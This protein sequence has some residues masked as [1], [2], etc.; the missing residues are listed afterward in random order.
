MRAIIALCVRR[1]GAVTALTLLALVLG[2]WGARDAPLDVFPEFVPSQVD[3]QTEA[4]GFSPQQVE[5]LVTKPVENAV[6]GASGLA[7]LRSE[8]IP[9]LSVVTI[10]FADN[11]DLHIA[12]QGIAER[13]S[14]IGSS[15]P[16][17][18]GVPKLSPMV[19][20]TMDLLKIGLVSD[21]VD[22]YTLR[23]T[24][25]WVIKPRL[26]AVPGV[27]H[28]IVFGG[29]V[30]QIQIQPDMQR[31]TS[32]GITLAEVADAARAAL[33]LR[34]AGFIDTTNQRVLMQSPIPAP[35]PAALANAVVTMRN[36]VPVRL[37]DIA[38]VKVA[39]AL[40]S[41]DT[42]IMG[43]PGILLSLASQYGANTLSTTLAVEQALSALRPAL[44]AQGITVYPGLQRPANFVER[45]LGNLRQ[46]LLIAGVLIF[47][48]LYLF[49]RDIRAA[50]IA[51]T[52]IPLSLLAAI[53]VLDRMG[54]TLNTM[55][56][57]GFAV[58]LGVLVDDAIIG[59]ENILRRLRENR[60]VPQPVDRLGVIREA[61]LEVRGPV[62]YAT[63]V[64]I[65]VFLPEIFTSS[66]Q[67]HFVG[68]LALAFIF[69]VVASL[70]VAMTATPAL[71]ALLLRDRDARAEARWL[72][73]LKSWQSRAVDGVA[74][75][76][77]VVAAVLVLC[78]VAAA[79]ALPFLGGTFMPDFREGHF[80]I[81]VS[82]SIPGTSLAAMLDVGKRI[83]AEVLA[84]PYVA[85]VE[86]Q[87]GRAELGED[88]WGPHRSEFHVELKPDADIDQGAAQDALRAI[89][90]HYP[91]LQSEVVTFLGDRIS[92]SLS[93]ET[94]QVAIK[95]FGDNLDDLD[96][97]G[98]R[99]VEALRKIPGVVDLEFKRQSGTP[100]IAIQLRPEALLASGLKAQ[101][102]LDTIE[103]AYS[104]T[105]VGQTFSGTRTVDAVVLLPDALRQQPAQLAQLMISGPTGPVPLSQIAS[106]G[107]TQDRY[108]IEHDGGQRR[109]SVNFN[110]KGASLQDVVQRAAQTIAAKVV[111]PTGVHTEFTGAAEEE[112]QT[113]NEL[114]LYSALALALIGMILFVSF[115]W[116]AN[117]YLVL[118]NL[119]FALVGSVAVIAATG[120]GLSLGTV[121]GLVTVF[122]VSAR[123]AILQL[124]HYEHLVEVEG[125]TWDIETVIRGAN[126]RLVPILMTA[127][128]TALGLAPLAFGMNLPGQEIEGPMAVTVLGGL[129]SST[130]LNLFVLPALARHYIKVPPR[131]LLT[132]NTNYA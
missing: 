81:Q 15:L 89:L 47:V 30:R 93:G 11:I 79:A 66:V 55:T 76:F 94:A 53:A 105:V 87:V 43:K 37:G 29:N 124:A 48:V 122:G 36:G 28:V 125:A 5:E 112:T 106:I 67:G 18:V 58:A 82:S 84:L 77:K 31:L 126:E 92:E 100:A 71:C 98:D 27:A 57:G 117:S 3:I 88:T 113:R 99:M 73:R 104:G 91:G 69:A 120:I 111:L 90:T 64:V 42:L 107:V 45:A 75:H 46:S 34:G 50:L 26:L 20:S 108:S 95:V 49:L 72:V 101:D 132:P 121:V 10:T 16:A 74:N 38:S 1:Y 85:S 7:T 114:L 123:N 129:V 65:A 35:D 22:P 83:S 59:I 62:I 109:I 78:V 86:Q 97:T 41:G 110:V 103:T 102:V 115:R 70:L 17:G 127:T 19:S 130:I 12:R 96:A 51:F 52:A 2:C 119:P 80:V 116:R 25:D 63:L 8:S 23:D 6:N 40:R 68:P 128:V 131:P 60:T 21:K 33:P 54:L 9:G 14:E 44:T 13:L 32:F 61:S 24:A 39:P 118:A 4:P 56:L